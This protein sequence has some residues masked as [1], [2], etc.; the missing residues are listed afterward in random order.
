MP[1]P[2]RTRTAA[3][4]VVDEVE[5]ARFERDG[6]TLVRADFDAYVAGRA[7]APRHPSPGQAIRLIPGGSVSV[8]AGGMGRVSGEF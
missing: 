5:I 4:A 7:S 1:P 3:I 8:C 6:Y 2:M